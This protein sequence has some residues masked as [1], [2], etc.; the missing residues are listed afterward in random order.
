METAYTPPPGDGEIYVVDIS[1]PA[2]L[3]LVN[4]ITTVDIDNRMDINNNLLAVAEGPSGVTFL[5]S[6][7]SGRSG[8]NQKRLKVSMNECYAVSLR[9]N[10]CY[11]ARLYYPLPGCN[12]SELGWR[13]SPFWIMN[14]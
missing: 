11:V 12:I 7:E 1:D 2:A 4:T 5:Y 13:T 8:K 9:E 14:P 10:F 3:R 6:C